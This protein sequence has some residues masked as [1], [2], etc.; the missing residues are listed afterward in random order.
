MQLPSQ[1]YRKERYGAIEKI[2][3]EFGISIKFC[4]CK[5]PDI[6]LGRCH[7]RPEKKAEQIQIG[8]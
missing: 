7:D 6:V 3:K 2:A 8:C 4:A 5:N 1:E